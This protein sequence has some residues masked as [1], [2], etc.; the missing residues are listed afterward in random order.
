[1]LDLM[2]EPNCPKSARQIRADGIGIQTGKLSMAFVCMFAGIHE[3][4]LG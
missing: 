2:A 3:F 1:M 4:A